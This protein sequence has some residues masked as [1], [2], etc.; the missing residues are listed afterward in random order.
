MKNYFQILVGKKQSKQ[1]WQENNEFVQ[2]F[3]FVILIKYKIKVS[4][5]FVLNI[6]SLQDYLK[7]SSHKQNCDFANLLQE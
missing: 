1:F 4:R 3:S 6:T 7:T 2:F 5:N